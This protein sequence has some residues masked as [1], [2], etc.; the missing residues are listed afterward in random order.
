LLSHYYNEPGIFTNLLYAIIL[1]FVTGATV[2]I[3]EFAFLVPSL[4]SITSSTSPAALFAS[5]FFVGMIVLGIISII[6]T[7]VSSVLVYR[8][9][10]KL[11]EK[12]GVGSFKTAGLLYLI[13]VLLSIVVI[14][15]I[16]S[17]IGFIVA[18]IGFYRLKP[19]ATQPAANTYYPQPP[20]APL[21]TNRCPNCGTENSPDSVYCS[22]CGKPKQ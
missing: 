2:L 21:Q 4:S 22:Y 14:G 17:W 5:S 12:S 19:T 1:N 18:A 8:A 6:V 7:V 15:G 11:G 9:H 20:P 13:G 10:N 16:I 3:A